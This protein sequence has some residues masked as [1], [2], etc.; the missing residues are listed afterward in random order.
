MGE[1]R[2]EDAVEGYRLVN[3]REMGKEVKPRNVKVVKIEGRWI[4]MGLCIIL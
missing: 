4:E 1:C 3:R 2:Q